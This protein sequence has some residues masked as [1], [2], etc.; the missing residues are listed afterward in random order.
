MVVVMVVVWWS[1]F[2]VVVGR[3]DGGGDGG[4]ASGT[5]KDVLVQ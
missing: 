1:P 2:G 4:G 3:G 5:R